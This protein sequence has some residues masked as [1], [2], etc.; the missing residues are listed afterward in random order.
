MKPTACWY[1]CQSLVKSKCL[2]PRALRMMRYVRVRDP[3]EKVHARCTC[4]LCAPVSVRASYFLL[5]RK[6]SLML[7][8]HD[9]A[10]AGETRCFRALGAGLLD[11][12]T[13]PAAAEVPVGTTSDARTPPQGESENSWPCFLLLRW[14]S[15]CSIM[16]AD[17]KVQPFNCVIG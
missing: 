4:C 3:Y 8:L 14:S 9:F 12:P 10:G 17:V 6:T 15:F 11:V 5:A 13:P 16:M 7:D 1:S 2:K